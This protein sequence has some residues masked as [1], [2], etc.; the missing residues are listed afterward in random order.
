MK[1]VDGYP[2][3]AASD[4]S[5]FLACRHLIRL[6]NLAALAINVSRALKLDGVGETK[7]GRERVVPLL[8]PLAEDLARI[9]DGLLFPGHDGKPW[10]STAFRNWRR[11]VCQPACLA[12]G[13]GATDSSGADRYQGPS[14][15]Y[16]R[17]SCASLLLAEGRNPI[18]V[19]ESMGHDISLRSP[20]VTV[21]RSNSCLDLR[22][23]V[24][25]GLPN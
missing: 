2:R 7:T 4:L 12:V 23:R 19:A 18:E 24:H 20:P 9:E 5:N 14:P 25:G 11:R 22:A 8:A 21:T 16:L 13:I 15:K 3:F 10:T 6:A 17:H 1:I